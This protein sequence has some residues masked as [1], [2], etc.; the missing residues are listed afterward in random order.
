MDA[1]AL[2]S[3]LS[4]L[5]IGEELKAQDLQAG[6]EVVV[7]GARA[8]SARYSQALALRGVSSQVVGDAATWAGLH[9][10]AQTLEPPP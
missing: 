8:L 2:P 1:Q 9:A 6:Q 7:I 5:L 4:G 10:L 3:Y